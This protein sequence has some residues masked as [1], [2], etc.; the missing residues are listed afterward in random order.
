MIQ[1]LCLC[2]MLLPWPKP[3]LSNRRSAVQWNFSRVSVVW[4]CPNKWIC[5]TKAK[6][7]NQN[8]CK[9]MSAVQWYYPLH[10]KMHVF[11][12]FMILHS[13]AIIVISYYV[14]S[15]Y[16]GSFYLSVTSKKLPNIYKSCPKNH[17]TI[18]IKDFDTF[19]KNA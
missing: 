10:I 13:H 3:K 18:K 11:P 8:Q 16:V 6:Q 1:L 9:R 2:W 5:L 19:T 14:P 12:D 17:F 4:I 7:L 15:T